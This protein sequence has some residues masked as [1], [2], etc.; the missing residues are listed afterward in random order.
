MRKH[1]YL[2]TSNL[3]Y[4]NELNEDES[5]ERIFEYPPY[6]MHKGHEYEWGRIKTHKNYYHIL[7]GNMPQEGCPWCG[8]PGKV[9]KLNSDSDYSSY[10]IKCLKCR[11]QGPVIIIDNMVLKDEMAFAE[12]ESLLYL[13]YKIRKSWDESL[14]INNEI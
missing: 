8:S 11:S 6:E 1:I 12:Y 4:I 13:Q 7:I 2:H 3:D 14:T 9:V 5:F 10:C